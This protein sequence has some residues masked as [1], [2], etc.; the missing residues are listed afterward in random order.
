[1]A[2]RV[3]VTGLGV[4][5]A[6]GADVES[7]W[8][9]LVAGRGAIGPLQSLDTSAFKVGIGAEVDAEVVRAGLKRLRRRPTDRAVDLGL[10]AA[11]DALEEAGLIDGA[12]PY[13]AQPVAVIL[14][15]GAGSAESHTTGHARFHERGVRG[16][17]PSTVPR[18]M[19]NSI[20]AGISIHFKLT[21]IN[22]VVVSACTSATNAIGMACR[23]VRDGY[24]DTV[25]CGGADGFF[26]PFY[27]G[28]W[29]NLG[30]MSRHPDPARAC[31]PFD[32]DR[33]GT[34]FGEGAGMLVVE[35]WERARGRGARIRGEVVGYGESSDASHLTSPSAEGQAVAMRDA[36]AS[37]GARPDELGAVNAHG[38]A[39]RA[40]DQCES[41]SIRAVLGDA[42]DNAPVSANKSYFGHTLGASGAI[43]AIAALLSIEHGVLPPNLNLEN[44][45]PE[46]RVRLVGGEPEPLERPLVMKNSFGFGGSNGVLVLGPG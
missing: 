26:D 16:L 36:L 14:G 41:E 6:I 43:E 28:I 23:M 33:D 24:A 12:P 13:E 22:Y 2:R 25:L 3:A 20:S 39:T 45:D 46:C 34:V 21:G 18:C 8:T 17:R 5:C 11:A 7:F 4:A 38:T 37:A 42:V 1:M 27:F 29:N 15:T 10:V 19:Y 35:S 32:A 44:P 9:N 31:R 30:V 40:N